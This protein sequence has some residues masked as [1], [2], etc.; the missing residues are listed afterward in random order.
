MFSSVMS[1][2]DK[3]KIEGESIL[4]GFEKMIDLVSFEHG[5][6]HP[7]T[8]DKSSNSRSAGRPVLGDL[9]IDML[10]NK[11][12]PKLIEACAAGK[13]LGKV[14]VT[15]LRVNEGKLSKIAT[16]S[17]ENVYVAK[18]L[19]LGGSRSSIGAESAQSLNVTSTHPEVAVHLNYDAITVS[20]VETDNTGKTAGTIA[21]G[22][23]KATAGS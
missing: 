20:Y 9:K 8:A 18:V 7:M 17:L 23:I 15:S 5:V 16:F 14:E 12:Y 21:S 19:M 6:D 4:A 2:S 10:M 11:A 13:N 3:F 1:I 22:T